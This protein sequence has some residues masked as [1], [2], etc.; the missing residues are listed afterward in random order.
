MLSGAPFQPVKFQVGGIIQ[1]HRLAQTIPPAMGLTGVP[2]PWLEPSR[3]PYSVV[4]LSSYC[5][6]L[7]HQEF[8]GNYLQNGGGRGNVWTKSRHTICTMVDIQRHSS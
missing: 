5:F 2:L 1:G 6:S 8:K 3:W 4:A 7:E